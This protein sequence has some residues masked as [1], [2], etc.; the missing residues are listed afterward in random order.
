LQAALDDRENDLSL[1]PLV[2]KEMFNKL[3]VIRA[4]VGDEYVYGYV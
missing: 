1:V 3:L 4:L 2:K